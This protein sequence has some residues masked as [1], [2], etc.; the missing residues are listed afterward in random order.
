MR[1]KSHKEHKYVRKYTGKKRSIYPYVIYIEGTGCRDSLKEAVRQNSQ[2]E[3]E[4]AEWK[5]ERAENTGSR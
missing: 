3:T 4:A 5:N 2:K 1:I